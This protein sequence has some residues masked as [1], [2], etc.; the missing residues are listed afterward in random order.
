MKRK[1]KNNIVRRVRAQNRAT[2]R[3]KEEEKK[4]RAQQ[5]NSAEK[6][7]Y[8]SINNDEKTTRKAQSR[9]RRVRDEPCVKKDPG[10]EK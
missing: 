3:K 9:A 6:H 7:I 1:S 4:R 8:K 5:K 10:T 2:Q